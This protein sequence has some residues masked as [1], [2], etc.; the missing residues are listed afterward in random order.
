V[1][2][3]APVGGEIG[4]KKEI[5][6][7]QDNTVRITTVDER[8]YARATNDP[9]TG[10]PA[11]WEFVPSVTWICGVGYVKGIAFYKWLASTG[12]D[13]AQ[14]IKN[15][16]AEKGSKVHQAVGDLL[17]GKTV[18]MD[19][20][21]INRETGHPEELSLQEYECL[22]AFRDWWAATKP[23][24]I[25]RE[26][27]LWGDG[28]AG[29]GD[30]LCTIRNTKTALEEPWLLDLKTGQYVWP[31]HELQVS[32]YKR[33]LPDGWQPDS[34]SKPLDKESVQ[35]GILQVG[36]RANK[37]KWK[38]T[39]VEDQ[40]DLFLAAKAI[41]AKETEGAAVLQRDYPLALTL[42]KEEAQ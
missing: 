37:R 38:L 16:A 4:M 14:A 34:M 31:E 20:Q 9:D 18:A 41:W 28:Y 25:A 35:L 2:L 33:A 19:A 21:Y 12:W 5:R 23:T 10:L 8:W 30:L 24:L 15:A 6:T 3:D 40:Y 39:P 13:E 1:W 29:T 17:D 27:V 32:A 26:F 11:K 42:T 22:M 7:V 36:Y